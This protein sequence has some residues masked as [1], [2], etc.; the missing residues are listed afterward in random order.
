MIKSKF[1]T[2]LTLIFISFIFLYP[3]HFYSY[4]SFSNGHDHANSRVVFFVDAQTNIIFEIRNSLE[5][6]AL[7]DHKYL[8]LDNYNVDRQNIIS[9]NA[10]KITFPLSLVALLEQFSRPPPTA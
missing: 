9:Y 1:T 4:D 5:E 2:K 6:E 7:K 8:C 10:Q 3:I